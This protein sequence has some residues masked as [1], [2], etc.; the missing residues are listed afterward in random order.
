MRTVYPLVRYH[1]PAKAV[2]WLVQA[3]GFEVH[4]LVT[5]DDGGVGHGE[6]IVGTG[7]IMTGR[8]EPGGPGIYIAVDDPDAHHDRAV[9]AGAE[10]ASGLADKDYGSRDYACKDPEGNLW[11]FGTYRP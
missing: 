4:E 9:A 2:D 10:V 3:F 6:L 7:M 8:G 1:D 5:A 11:Y